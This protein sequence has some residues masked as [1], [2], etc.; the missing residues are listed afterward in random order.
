MRKEGY[1][2]FDYYLSRLEEDCKH[3]KPCKKCLPPQARKTF[4]VD[5][6]CRNHLPYPQAQCDSCMA[7]TISLKEQ[8]YTHVN[9]VV[10]RTTAIYRVTESSRI[11][12]LLGREEKGEVFVEDVY[13]PK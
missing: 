2:T 8:N 1:E 4:G 3:R 10:I 11:G 5:R 13:F 6:E 7:P 12:I 9:K